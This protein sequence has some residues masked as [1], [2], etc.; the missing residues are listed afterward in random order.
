MGSSNGHDICA[1][2]TN[3][4]NIKGAGTL[5]PSFITTGSDHQFCTTN[6]WNSVSLQPTYK[7]TCID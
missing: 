3:G 4:I 1:W 5:P 6:P 2:M 7:N